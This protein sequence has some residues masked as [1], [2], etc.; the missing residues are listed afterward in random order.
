MTGRRGAGGGGGCE[1][2]KVNA[3]MASREGW[4]VGGAGELCR[5]FVFQLR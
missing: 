2:E 4:F 5:M 3:G 1:L